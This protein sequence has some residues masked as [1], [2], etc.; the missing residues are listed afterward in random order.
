[1]LAS[2]CMCWHG[3]SLN[4]LV[5]VTVILSVDHHSHVIT[6]REITFTLKAGSNKS[7]F[8]WKWAQNEP[9]FPTSS[10]GHFQDVACQDLVSFGWVFRQDRVGS[11]AS[12]SLTR[13]KVCLPGAVYGK[14]EV[15]AKSP[16]WLIPQGPPLLPSESLGSPAWFSQFPAEQAYE[17]QGP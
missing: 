11:V 1:M 15:G 13:V 3:H 9:I 5:S 14:E 17:S 10:A 16:A 4:P 2:F 7:Y 6:I 12:C 8:C